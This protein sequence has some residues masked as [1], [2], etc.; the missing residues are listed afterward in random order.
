MFIKDFKLFSIITVSEG[1]YTVGGVV[2]EIDEF[3]PDVPLLAYLNVPPREINYGISFTEG[4][5]T[6][7]YYILN[8]LGSDT[9]LLMVYSFVPY[10]E[11]EEDE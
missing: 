2:F 1:N 10:E 9:G 7:Y 6:K 11:V 3:S 5:E 8:T 4:N